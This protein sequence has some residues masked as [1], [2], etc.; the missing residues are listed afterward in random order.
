MLDFAS[1]SPP[2]SNAAT[3]LSGIPA[4]PEFSG[5]ISSETSPQGFAALLDSAGFSQIVPALSATAALSITLPTFPPSTSQLGMGLPHDTSA[6]SA[7]LSN[8]GSAALPNI[9]SAALPN[10]GS[11]LV[12]SPHAVIVPQDGNILPQTLAA[13]RPQNNPA[14]PLLTPD[15]SG[16]PAGPDTGA[17][18]S[19]IALVVGEKKHIPLRATRLAM[20]IN[21]GDAPHIANPLAPELGQESDATALDTPQPTSD[22]TVIA[23]A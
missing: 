19:T 8:I 21:T 6:P 3:A 10:I 16:A 17:Q 1:L 20:P 13:S 4:S 12:P 5:N 14:S 2:T 9:G 23:L 7:A 11:A 15:Q 18:P 22:P